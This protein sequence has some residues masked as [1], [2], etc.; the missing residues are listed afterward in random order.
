MYFKLYNLLI[1]QYT[2]SLQF[3]TIFGE[4]EKIL[5]FI[6]LMDKIWAIYCYTDVCILS[7]YR[8]SSICLFT[9]CRAQFIWTTFPHCLFDRILYKIL[10]NLLYA[11]QLHVI[12]IVCI[13][14]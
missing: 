8:M 9:I 6:I 11:I 2:V 4:M 7:L 14:I 10:K 3:S 13:H 12:M 1:I 5:A